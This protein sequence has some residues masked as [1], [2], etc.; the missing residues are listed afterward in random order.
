MRLP[1]V[2]QGRLCFLLRKYT[3]R[4]YHKNSDRLGLEMVYG[5]I[6]RHLL[7]LSFFFSRSAFILSVSQKHSIELLFVYVYTFGRFYTGLRVLFVRIWHS[8]C[9]T[10]NCY[11]M[12]D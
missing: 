11:V 3:P 9:Y 6:K 8:K 5:W 1:V 4:T 2:L 12:S 10:I 7:K